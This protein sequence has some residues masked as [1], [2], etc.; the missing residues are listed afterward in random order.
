MK[1][2]TFSRCNK[3]LGVH[4]D[5]FPPIKIDHAAAK[6]KFKAAVKVMHLLRPGETRDF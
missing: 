4:Y 5:T 1:A 2:A 6:K 3:L